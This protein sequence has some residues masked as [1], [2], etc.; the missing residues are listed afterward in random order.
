MDLLPPL[1]VALRTDVAAEI[2]LYSRAIPIDVRLDIVREL[3]SHGAVVLGEDLYT[4]V[5][6][7]DVGI[8]QALL[9]AGGAA[10][11]SSFKAFIAKLSNELA[12]D[13]NALVDAGSAPALL[14]HARLV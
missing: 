4:A 13:F 7:G 9:E 2:G 11:I 10:S 12:A 1:C 6:L 8:V 14:L 5:Q 3:L